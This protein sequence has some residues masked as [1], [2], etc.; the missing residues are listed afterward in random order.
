MS[1]L[2]RKKQEG[3]L[4]GQAD[5]AKTLLFHLRCVCGPD[6][7]R[8]AVGEKE[9][10]SI[11]NMF[12]KCLTKPQN[13]KSKLDRQGDKFVSYGNCIWQIL[14]FFYIWNTVTIVFCTCL[15]VCCSSC[16]LL[17][18]EVIVIEARDI[19]ALIISF[20]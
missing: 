7:G 16:V 3:K 6:S 19:F 1:R 20:Q 4:I 12:S 8:T 14:L 13:V 15:I 17:F 11:I 5:R 2:Q 10:E 18:Q 9:R